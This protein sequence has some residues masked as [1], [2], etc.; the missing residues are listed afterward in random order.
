MESAKSC[1]KDNIQM[2]LSTIVLLAATIYFVSKQNYEFLVYSGTLIFLIL[3]IYFTDKKFHYNA[4]AKWGF[5]I[6]M[7][8]HMAGGSVYIGATRLYDFILIPLVGEP[9]LILKYDQFV[10]FFCYVVITLLTF[11]VLKTIT[12][13]DYNKVTFMII[14]I[15]A[16]SSIGA[17]NEMI[18]FST[19]VMFNAREAVGGYENT[20][21]DICSNF[22]GALV[23]AFYLLFRKEI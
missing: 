14:L 6:W 1:I 11:T 21:I 4:A 3:L 19:V 22:L 16:G 17:I 5:F 7:A 12:K 10:H 13:K 9:Y 8:L 23:A 18:E 2:F 15:L 20:L